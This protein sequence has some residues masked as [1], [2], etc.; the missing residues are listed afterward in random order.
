M[1][2]M[3]ISRLLWV[4]VV[5]GAVSVIAAACSQPTSSTQQPPDPDVEPLPADRAEMGIPLPDGTLPCG[6]GQVEWG[7][8]IFDLKQYPACQALAPALTVYCLNDQAQWTSDAIAVT[9][10][11][12]DSITLE[13]QREGICGVFP[14]K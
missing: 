3:S 2:R 12:A 1:T 4:A 14:S 5:M 9:E 11:S 6:L 10:V 13:A 7:Q 8:Q